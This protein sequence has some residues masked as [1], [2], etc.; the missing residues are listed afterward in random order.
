MFFVWWI[1]SDYIYCLYEAAGCCNKQFSL[2]ESITTT[3]HTLHTSL[4]LNMIMLLTAIFVSYFPQDGEANSGET[5]EET[6][7]S[8]EEL[9]AHMKKL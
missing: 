2:P 1:L 8:L 4:P 3:P 6:E 9:M 5:V 7:E